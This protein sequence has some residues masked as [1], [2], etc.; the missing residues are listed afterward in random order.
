MSVTFNSC[1]IFSYMNVSSFI[2][3][4]LWWAFKVSPDFCNE[5]QC[6]KRAFLSICLEWH[7]YQISTWQ[8][9]EVELLGQNV[10]ALK[11]IIAITKSLSKED[12]PIYIYERSSF[13]AT[14][15]TQTFI[16]LYLYSWLMKM[17]QNKL[18]FQL[19]CL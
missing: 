6:C 5:K 15:P 2:I 16:K 18:L 8:Y 7:S 9:L 13:P 17:A 11:K 3:Q 4:F 14:W 19:L 10:Y 12:E 1:I